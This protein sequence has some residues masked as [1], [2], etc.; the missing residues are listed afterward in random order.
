M[1]RDGHYLIAT[2]FTRRKSVMPWSD[3]HASA[4]P[5]RS[6]SNELPVHLTPANTPT[7]LL[8]QRC[9]SCPKKLDRFE[10]E[11]RRGGNSAGIQLGFG[12]G[13]CEPEGI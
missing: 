5:E 9:Q 1:S 11:D 10:V 3:L 8:V 6:Q 12:R 2:A 7:A 4:V 13:F